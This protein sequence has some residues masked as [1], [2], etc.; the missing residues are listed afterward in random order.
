MEIIEFKGTLPFKQKFELDGKKWVI[1]FYYRN[2]D[3]TVMC[4]L[5]DE[6][7]KVL[8]R[9]NSLRYGEPLFSHLL[10]DRN[11]LIRLDFPQMLLVPL[12]FDG[13]ERRV[14]KDNF[15]K[16]ILI[17]LQDANWYIPTSGRVL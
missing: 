7:N 16:E 17:T 4:D 11:Q 1:D 15:L 13:V 10:P 9:N 8:S 2:I 12:S 14:G 5:Y 3:D 6:T